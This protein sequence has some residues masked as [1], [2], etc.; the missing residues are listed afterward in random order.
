M[1]LENHVFDRANTLWLVINQAL[2]VFKY[3]NI[4]TFCKLVP[5]HYQMLEVLQ[6]YRNQVEL[7]YKFVYKVQSNTK[8]MENI[9]NECPIEA[10]G[11]Y[12]API[13]CIYLNR[14]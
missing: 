14:S 3:I 5:T 6:S 10:L 2:V 12:V 7:V 4:L 8:F 9:L 1:F 13:P 11:Y